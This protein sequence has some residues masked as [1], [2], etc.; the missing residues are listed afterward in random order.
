MDRSSEKSEGL[1]P[2][3]KLLVKRKIPD[4]VTLYTESTPCCLK[5]S[6]Q[7]FKISSTSLLVFVH[8]DLRHE[9][10]PDLR[11]E[12]HVPKAREQPEVLVDC[13]FVAGR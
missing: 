3:S 7:P 13:S 10:H 1:V 12:V 9:V 8:P 2:V 6:S 11:H 4:F 5:P